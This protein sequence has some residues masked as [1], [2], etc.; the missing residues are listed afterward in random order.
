MRDLAVVVPDA[1]PYAEVERLIRAGA[2]EHLEKLELFDVYRGKP[3][4]EGQKSL[5]FHLSFRHPERTL[6][7]QETDGFMQNI[8]AALEQKGFAIRR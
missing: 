7:D 5:A 8:I 1:T 4:E 2:G 3:L 6:T